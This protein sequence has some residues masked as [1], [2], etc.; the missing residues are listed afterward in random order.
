MNRDMVARKIKHF[1]L[2]L[3]LFSLHQI[4]NKVNFKHLLDSYNINKA[5][6][7]LS[8]MMI[9]IIHL[10]REKK[11]DLIC[12]SNFSIESLG[13]CVKPRVGIE[14]MEHNNSVSCSQKKKNTDKNES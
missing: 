8:I 13:V 7:L 2:L 5:A 12:N 1:I 4:Q 14:S 9:H 6:L 11:K 3:F 10:Y